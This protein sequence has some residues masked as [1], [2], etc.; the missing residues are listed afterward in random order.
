MD[1]FFTRRPGAVNRWAWPAM[2]ALPVVYVAV[3][4]VLRADA[5][6][7][8]LWHNLD[9]D[10][11][12]LLDSLNIVNLTTPG[13]VYHPGTTVQWLGALVLKAAYPFTGPGEITGAVLADPERHLRLIGTVIVALNGGALYCLG[14]VRFRML[15]ESSR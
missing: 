8:W 4:L 6:P 10:Y 14:V 3:T 2:A 12:Y 5:M 1:D 11:F 15:R 9:P 13:H 7:F